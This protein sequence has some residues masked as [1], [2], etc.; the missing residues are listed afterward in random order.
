MFPKDREMQSKKKKN[1]RFESD[2]TGK[3]EMGRGFR[4]LLFYK[5]SFMELFDSLN[6]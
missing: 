5:I 1:H 4:G 6:Y 2:R 3:Q